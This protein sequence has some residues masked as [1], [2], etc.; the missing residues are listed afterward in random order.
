[1]FYLPIHQQNSFPQSPNCSDVFRSANLASFCGFIYAAVDETL[2]DEFVAKT[3]W[4]IGKLE[5]T[6]EARF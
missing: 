4:V 1:M 6:Q 3:S 5:R 2:V